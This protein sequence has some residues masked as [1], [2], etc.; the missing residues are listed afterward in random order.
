MRKSTKTILS[1]KKGFRIQDP[2]FSS[3]AIWALDPGSKTILN[4]GWIIK[5]GILDF[6]TVRQYSQQAIQDGWP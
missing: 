3:L 2:G 1:A 6:A 5:S 4:P